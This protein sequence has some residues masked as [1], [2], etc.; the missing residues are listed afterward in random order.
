LEPDEQKRRRENGRYDGG[1]KPLS[2]GWFFQRNHASGLALG[3]RNF[4]AR[5]WKRITQEE[6]GLAKRGGDEDPTGET[7]ERVRFGVNE[8]VTRGEGLETIHSRGWG[9]GQILGWCQR[10]DN[11]QGNLQQTKKEGR[12]KKM[13]GG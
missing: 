11:S 1:R 6:E 7:I 3:R 5:E 9:P 8:K 2:E 13:K 10:R 12:K 4:L